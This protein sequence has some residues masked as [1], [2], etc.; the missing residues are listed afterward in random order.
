[1]DAVSDVGNASDAIDSAGSIE[2]SNTGGEVT[3]TL[4]VLDEYHYF[5]N[6]GLAGSGHI[7]KKDTTGDPSVVQKAKSTQDSLNIVKK[8]KA[9]ED[10]RNGGGI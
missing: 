8:K 5:N 1:V 7:T 2:T 6:R 4:D 9:L 3:I 10:Y